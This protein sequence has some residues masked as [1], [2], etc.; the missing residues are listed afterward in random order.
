LADT[1]EQKGL[2]H[3]LLGCRDRH[4]FHEMT[5]HDDDSLPIPHDHVTGKHCRARASDRHIVGDRDMQA[6]GKPP[7]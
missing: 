3:F 2:E 6:L 4:L 5:R 7:C 1:L